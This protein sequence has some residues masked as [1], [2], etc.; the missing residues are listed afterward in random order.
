MILDSEG[1]EVDEHFIETP[2]YSRFATDNLDPYVFQVNRKT[3]RKR[4]VFRK[5]LYSNSLE[6]KISFLNVEFLS[7]IWTIRR[8]P[9]LSRL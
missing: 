4:H 6:T 1:C 7:A 3:Y 2:N 8:A 9:A 5:W